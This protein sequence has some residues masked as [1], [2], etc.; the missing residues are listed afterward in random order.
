M[1]K[2]NCAR[3]KRARTVFCRGCSCGPWP[4]R[5]EIGTG[6][7][8]RSVDYETFMTKCEK[9]AEVIARGRKVSLRQSDIA[10]WGV[11]PLLAEVKSQLSLQAFEDCMDAPMTGGQSY[12]FR[13]RL[14][15]VPGGGGRL[16]AK[17]VWHD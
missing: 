15:T 5:P 17:K 4:D 1:H 7:A 8:E 11:Q 12:T 16:V 6:T 13:L 10:A 14:E 3:K 9:A 2:S